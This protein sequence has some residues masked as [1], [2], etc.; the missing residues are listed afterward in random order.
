MLR[1]L[2]A[3]YLVP[4]L[5]LSASVALATGQVAVVHGVPGL[6]V[7][8]YVNG[9]L[10]LED[11]E[12]GTVTDPLELEAGDY[13]LAVTAADA[14]IEEAVLTGTATL[15]DGAFVSVVAHLS[16]DGDPTLSLFEIDTSPSEEGSRL[17][18]I[19]VAAAPAVDIGLRRI[20]RDV[21]KIEGVENGDSPSL[22]L[23]P[24]IYF[25]R[26]FPAGEDD[27]VFGPAK[28]FLRDG[29]SHVVYAI[30]S[31]ADE[32][33]GLLK[34]K[35]AIVQPEPE[36]ESALVTA[37][38]GVPGLVVDVFVN[39]ELTLDDFEPGTV[40]DPLELEAGEYTIAITAA[41]DGDPADP[42]LSA[43]VA[44]EEGQ[45]ASV[46]AHLQEDGTPTI[47]AYL[48]DTS[49]LRFFRGR[50]VTRHNAAAPA[51]D[52][53]L[54]RWFWTVA[55]IEDLANGEEAQKDVFAGSYSATIFPA[56][57]S[58]A[59]F[60]PAGV[61]VKVGEVLIVYAVGSLADES[62]G[63]LTQTIDVEDP[64]SNL[65]DRIFRLFGYIF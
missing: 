41:E 16:A 13:D 43:T 26:I 6:V 65:L 7:D 38:H 36:P 18:A 3:A 48:N 49:S 8:V 53:R 40:T 19:H 35:V 47:T 15:A 46:V 31:L 5:F 12:P 64:L 56:G 51:V 61:R 50:L 54:K 11:F 25:A 29:C 17:T 30:G 55:K 23:A 14:P 39:G 59:V 62:F 34:Q 44:L 57:S 33:F 32:T 21:G 10:T 4:A 24:G 37:V 28:L 2:S 27:P 1:T 22:D 9:D 45:N 52:I 58:D 42:I 20:F 63:L 60:G